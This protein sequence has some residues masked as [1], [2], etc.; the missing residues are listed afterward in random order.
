MKVNYNF[1]S[2]LHKFLISDDWATALKSRIEI[3]NEELKITP[4]QNLENKINNAKPRN[5]K[6]KNWKVEDVFSEQAK[7]NIIKS[8]QKKLKSKLA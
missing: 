5:D 7:N 4:Q 8:H 3:I 6:Q 1:L 2:T